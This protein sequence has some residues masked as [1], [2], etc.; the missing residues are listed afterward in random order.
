MDLVRLG[1]ELLEGREDAALDLLACCCD[2][3]SFD[4]LVFGQA[5]RPPSTVRHTPVTY[6]AP[7]DARKR[8]H[9]ATS[10]GVPARCAGTCSSKLSAMPSVM[11]VSIRPGAT[12]VTVTPRRATRAAAGRVGANRPALA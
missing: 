12:A 1:A 7:S 8:T 9:S 6:A 2:C 3:H 11:S 5:V 4:L 10:S